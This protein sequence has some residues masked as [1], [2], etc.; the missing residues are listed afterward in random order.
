MKKPIKKLSLN[1]MTISNLDAS[2][3]HQRLGGLGKP[4]TKADCTVTIF[5]SICNCPQTKGGNCSYGT[6]CCPIKWPE[7]WGPKA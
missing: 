6:L 4:N 1:K 5:W 7:T 3:M 2:E